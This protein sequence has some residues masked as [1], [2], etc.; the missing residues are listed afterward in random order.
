MT[1][2]SS[3][4][5]ETEVGQLGVMQ[6]KRTWSKYAPYQS[7]SGISAE[8][9]LERSVF[10]MLGINFRDALDYLLSAQPSFQEFELW[11]LE[12]AGKPNTNIVERINSH[13]S[14]TIHSTE[15]ISWFSEIEA[16]PNVLSEQDLDCWDKYGYVIVRNAIS[17]EDCLATRELIC[18]YIG[19]SYQNPDSWHKS[20]NTQGL[21]VSLKYHKLLSK[22]RQNVRIKKAFSQLWQ[23]ADIYPSV[24]QCGFNPP[25]NANAPYKGQPIHLDVNFMKPIEFSTQGILYLTDTSETQGALTIVPGF[26]NQYSQWLK[27][28]PDHLR[29]DFS[30]YATKSIAANAG[31]FIIW[32]HHLPHSSSPNYEKSPRITQFINYL[33]IPV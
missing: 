1:S 18:D 9:E 2:T 22:N 15:L 5:S 3:L 32:H 20:R 17:P 33:P 23:S 6:L 11:C 19:V 8:F 31:D 28:T 10:D 21:W 12:I 24:D 27:E 29:Q 13:I 26:H 4:V 30:K 16:M 7:A 25:V 14:K